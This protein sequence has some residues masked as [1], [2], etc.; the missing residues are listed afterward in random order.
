MNLLPPKTKIL[1]EET[2][3]QIHA[4][5]TRF[6]S[7]EPFRVHSQD[8]RKSLAKAG[9][10][11]NDNAE[12]VILPPELVNEAI[13]SFPS[14]FNMYDMDGN[15]THIAKGTIA[16]TISSY[17]E[18]VQWLDYGAEHLRPST[19]ADMELALRLAEN[20]SS[21]R[22]ER[23]LV[24][25]SATTLAPVI[26]CPSTARITRRDTTVHSLARDESR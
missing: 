17:A 16:N 25:R 11:V 12:T 8:M 10:K 23:S 1:N 22:T 21:D 15:P 13:A 20:S 14:E 18:A 6:L 24:L 2:C 19:S 9:A 4:E 26:E 5:A 3:K 7:S